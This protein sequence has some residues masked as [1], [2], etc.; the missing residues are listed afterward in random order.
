MENNKKKITR[1]KKDTNKQK[2]LP[3]SKVSGRGASVLGEIIGLIISILLLLYIFPRLSF[4]TEDYVLWLPIALWTTVA[5]DTFKIFKHLTGIKALKKFFEVISLLIAAYAIYKF[6]EI[7][8][9]DLAVVGYSNVD[10]VVRT[11]LR[12]AVYALLLAV[13]ANV[14]QVFLPLKRRIRNGKKLSSEV[15]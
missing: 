4:V 8:P 5:G 11:A 6:I 12:F 7:Y 15:K 10:P 3:K 1:K 2:D 14:I 9:I 13:F